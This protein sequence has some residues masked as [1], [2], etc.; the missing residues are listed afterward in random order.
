[1]P[2]ILLSSPF[3]ACFEDKESFISLFD[4]PT[5]LILC[6]GGSQV[7]IGSG[8]PLCICISFGPTTSQE[9]FQ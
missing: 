3:Q 4:F 2:G 1:M 5:R 9:L 7:D 8:F 6:D